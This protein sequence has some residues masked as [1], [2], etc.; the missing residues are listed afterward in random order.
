M[1]ESQMTAHENMVVDYHMFFLTEHR[2]QPQG[3]D[4]ENSLV[5]VEPGFA[6]V[7]TGIAQGDVR[8]TV[9]VHD[10]A[11]P[12]DLTGWEEAA[13]V[14]LE[15]ATGQMVVAAVMA[16][17]PDFPVLTPHGP[18]HYRVRVHARGRDTAVDAVVFEP[19]ED[20]LIQVWPAPTAPQIIYKQ[21]DEYGARLL[22]AAARR[23][24]ARGK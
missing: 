3:F 14:T 6:A 12:V 20:Y 18:G 11:P 13:E 21:T 4:Y 1:S 9:E 15:S 17:T 2:L 7:Q 16:H 10:Q 19:V 23:K 24:A 22:Q 5:A 8:L